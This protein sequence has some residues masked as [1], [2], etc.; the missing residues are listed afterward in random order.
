M[1]LHRSPRRQNP[2][3][4]ARYGLL[5]EL[6][7]SRFEEFA[8]FLGIELLVN[9]HS[10]FGPCPIHGGDKATALNIYRGGDVPGKWACYTRGCERTFKK[11]LLGFVRGVLSA[12][13]VGWVPGSERVYGWRETLDVCCEFLG[14]AWADLRVDANCVRHDRL[15]ATVQSWC[16]HDCRLVRPVCS[17]ESLASLAESR[18]FASRGFSPSVLRHFSVGD[19]LAPGRPMT[20]RAVVP[21]FWREEVVGLTGRSFYD[22]CPLCGRWHLPGDCPS[23]KVGL[24]PKW[25]HWPPGLCTGHLLYNADAALP[26]DS[27]LLVEG[28]GCVWKLAEAGVLAVA[29]FGAN[30]SDAQQILLETAGCRVAYCGFD[31][32]EAGEA[33]FRRA[34]EDMR[35]VC[36]VVRVCPPAHDWAESPLGEIRGAVG[37]LNLKEFP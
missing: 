11:S 14:V 16:R 6:L 15:N 7:L 1:T 34:Q 19:C 33:G 35:R 12:Q 32:D 37:G 28:P 29:T 2:L 4:Q 5:T 23:Q 27:V 21:I 17:R 13:R 25:L 18:Y 10:F 20:N 8:D 30:V 36:S 3:E 9:Q 26:H 31:N 22:C 24:H